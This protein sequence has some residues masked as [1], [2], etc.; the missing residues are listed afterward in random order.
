MHFVSK[1]WFRTTVLLLLV[2]LAGIAC[3]AAGAFL[4]DIPFKGYPEDS[5]IVDI[6]HGTRLIAIADLLQQEGIILHRRAFI[7]AMAVERGKKVIRAGEYSFDRPMNEFEVI[8]K[9]LRG[10]VHYRTVTIPEGANLF[11]I[12]DL[13]EEAGLVKREAFLAAAYHDALIKDLAPDA[14]S[15]EGYLFPDTYKFERNT[16][17]QEILGKMVERFRKF[18]TPEYLAACG[19]RGL[20]LHQAVILASLIEKETGDNDERAVVS[21]VFQNR[22][23]RHQRLEC[24]PT[25][26]YA[27]LV[28]NRYRGKIFRSD[29]Q[30]DSPFNTYLQTGLPLGPIANPGRPS[31]EAAVHPAQVDYL[32]FVA[33]STG[34]HTFSRTLAQHEVAVREYRR[35][36]GHELSV[37]RPDPPAKK[38]GPPKRPSDR[39]SSAP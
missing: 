12:G 15:L 19:E 14:V 27:A 33:K 7:V 5:K 37:A 28:N 22:L 18:L 39:S 32:Y 34:G 36:A 30:I 24:D 11:A 1:F 29:M 35:T 6:P 10:E 20:T 16:P 13:V 21:A 38:G 17:V 25:V 23:S 26:I 31:L 8:R 3:V 4:L 9:L 2:A